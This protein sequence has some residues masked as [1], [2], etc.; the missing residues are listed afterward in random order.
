MKTAISLPDDLFTLADEFAKLLG[1]SRSELYA[2][3]LRRYIESHPANDLT[4]KINAFCATENTELPPDIAH[5]V[6]RKLLEVE[7]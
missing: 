7:W 3:A 5:V 2:T 1:V 4:Q 6:R